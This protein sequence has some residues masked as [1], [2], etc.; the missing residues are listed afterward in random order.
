MARD[1]IY[2]T[3]NDK[4]VKTDKKQLTILQY[5]DI[6]NYEIGSET[7]V[8]NTID[9]YRKHPSITAIND[10]RNKRKGPL[11]LLKFM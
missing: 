8:D 11:I 4:I 2:L 1:K 9:P 5:A 7:V 10:R 6:K 3:K